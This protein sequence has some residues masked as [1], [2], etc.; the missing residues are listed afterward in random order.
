LGLDVIYLQAKRYQ[1]DATISSE[2]IRGFSGALT[3][4]GA[5]KGV[6]VATC[7]FSPSAREF[8]A[9]NKLQKMV[10]IDGNDFPPMHLF[11]CRTIPAQQAQKS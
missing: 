2:V 1:P 10:L 9:N 4:K 8:A 6:F 5:T 7:K 3:G 11:D